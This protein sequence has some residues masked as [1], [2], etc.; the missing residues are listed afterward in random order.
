LAGEL[1]AFADACSVRMTAVLPDP[2]LLTTAAD[3]RIYRR[4]SRRVVP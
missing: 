4:H 2:V 3:F 1:R